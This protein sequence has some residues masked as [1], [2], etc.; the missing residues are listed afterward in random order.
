VDKLVRII[1]EIKRW[2]INVDTTT[3]GFIA[4]SWVHS[5]MEK[6]HGHP[7]DTRLFE[8]V[9]D[10]LEALTPLGLQLNLWKAQ[11]IYFSIRKN[12]F[13]VTRKK[14]ETGDS[15]SANWVKAF[16]KLGHYLHVKI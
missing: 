12:H 9:K 14:A 6:L 2:S 7:E 13:A 15:F 4:S 8:L 10:T 11:N 3:V 1:E 16:S 5:V